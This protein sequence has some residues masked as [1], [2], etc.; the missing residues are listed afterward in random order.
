MDLL[1]LDA[2]PLREDAF[3]SG[4]GHDEKGSVGQV[5]PG[6]STG[7][8]LPVAHWADEATRAA[9]DLEAAQARRHVGEDAEAATARAVVAGGTPH[10]RLLRRFTSRLR[11]RHR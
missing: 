3:S 2:S 10:P 4:R 6:V 1:A 5:S 7:V 8:G 11:L 9:K